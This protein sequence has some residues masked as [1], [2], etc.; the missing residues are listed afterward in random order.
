M[1]G[2]HHF[3]I[4][5][6]IGQTAIAQIPRGTRYGINHGISRS[7]KN[8]NKKNAMANENNIVIGINPEEYTKRFKGFSTLSDSSDLVDDS[9]ASGTA[10]TGTNH[11][12]IANNQSA[13][14]GQWL[15]EAPK[16]SV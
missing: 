1:V 14:T 11:V 3:E 5:H 2:M 16:P 8:R 6:N 9:Q 13:Q 12:S 7:R 4:S 10:T 15:P